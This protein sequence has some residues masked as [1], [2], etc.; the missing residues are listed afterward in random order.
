[1]ALTALVFLPFLAVA[2]RGDGTACYNACSGHG[3]CRYYTCYCDTGF[4]GESCDIAYVKGSAQ[5]LPVL[6]AGH[7]NITQ[8]SHAK[9]VAK[10]RPPASGPSSLL[11]IGYSSSSCAACVPR[12]QDYLNISA[13]LT[14][15]K[16]CIV[17]K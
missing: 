10:T 14:K 13:D 6:S 1:M 5:P 9:F 17:Q 12:E 4:H 2:S 3:E 7:F 8:S 16:V 11:V 15:L